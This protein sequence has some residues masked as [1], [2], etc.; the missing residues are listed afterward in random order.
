MRSACLCSLA[1]I[2]D[3]PDRGAGIL[4]DEERT[5]IVDGNADRAAPQLAVVDYEAGGEVFVPTGRYPVLGLKRF[6]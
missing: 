5:I 1:G 6:Q 3:A 4:G 2:S